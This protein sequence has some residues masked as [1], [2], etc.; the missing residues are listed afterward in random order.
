VWCGLPNHFSEFIYLKIRI[1]QDIKIEKTFHCHRIFVGINYF[2]YAVALLS[3]SLVRYRLRPP[4]T[5]L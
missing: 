4:T 1:F 2:I 3:L 5:H